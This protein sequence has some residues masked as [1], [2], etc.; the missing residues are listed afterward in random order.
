MIDIISFIIIFVMILFFGIYYYLGF[1]KPTSLQI[2]L[3]GIHIILFGGILFLNGHQTM[4]FLIMNLGLFV[5]VFGTF[6]NKGQ[7]TNK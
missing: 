3:L 2:Q 6:S 4:N 5:G 1:I 7:S